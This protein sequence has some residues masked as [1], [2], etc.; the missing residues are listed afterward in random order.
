M[1]GGAGISFHGKYRIS[2]ENFL[3]SMPETA[4]ESSSFHMMLNMS[5]P[6]NCG[7]KNVTQPIPIQE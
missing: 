4:I 7:Q 6:P 2:T 1:G 5:E 3:F